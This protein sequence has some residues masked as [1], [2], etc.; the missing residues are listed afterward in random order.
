MTDCN[1]L[2]D[3][4]WDFK[5]APSAIFISI[6]VC[7]QLASIPAVFQTNNKELYFEEDMV[8]H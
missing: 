5:L 2:C 6:V 4:L 3:C 8:L 7:F 1:S